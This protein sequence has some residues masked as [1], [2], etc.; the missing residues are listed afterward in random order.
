MS[1]HRNYAAGTALY[2]QSAEHSVSVAFE[3]GFVQID[4]AEMYRNEAS[5]GSAIGKL[6]SGPNAPPRQSIFVT[7]KL[8]TIPDGKTVKDSI[9]ESL[10]K[11]QINYIDL[12]L[13][14]TPVPHE[15]RIKEVWE[16]MEEVYKE[17]LA[18][19]IGVS[20]FRPKDF[21]EFIDTA[22]VIPAVNQIEFNPYLLNAVEPFL[23]L[24][25]KYNILTVSY[26][27]LRLGKEAGKEVTNGQVLL[28]WLDAYGALPITTSSKKDRLINLLETPKLPDL[29]ADELYVWPGA[30]N[31]PS[32]DSQCLIAILYLQLSFPGRFTIVEC[33]NPDISPLGQLPFLVHGNHSVSTVSAIVAYLEGLEESTSPRPI[34]GLDHEY[35]VT[36]ALDHDLSPAEVAKTVAWTSYIDS[37]LGDLVLQ[38]FYALAPNFRKLTLPTLASFLPIPQKYYIPSRLRDMYKPRLEAAGLWELADDDAADEHGAAA[39]KATKWMRNPLDKA[40]EGTVGEEPPEQV[41]KAFA[42]EK[43]IERAKST[44]QL[45]ADL[46]PEGSFAFGERPTPLD[47]HLTAHVLLI[48]HAPLPNPLLRTLVLESFPTLVDHALLV[49]TFAFPSQPFPITHN[50]IPSQVSGKAQQHARQLPTSSPPLPYPPIQ[51]LQHL[52][53]GESFKLVWDGVLRTARS[54]RIGIPGSS[55]SVS[56]VDLNLDDA[57]PLERAEA[58]AEKDLKKW[59]W[60]FYTAAG[61][62]LVTYGI[63]SGILP[64][65]VGLATGMVRVEVHDGEEEEDG[66]HGSEEDDE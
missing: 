32:I 27:G 51:S 61:V 30:W 28:K 43:V 7:T 31:L 37:N 58:E 22:E 38:S 20:N 45:L 12:Y 56:P 13:I 16:Q 6:L 46:I 9:K 64:L 11:L 48:L 24:H 33:A 52:S 66:Q 10:R 17:G 40:K 42:R 19:N 44:F 60:A 5:V 3:A 39:Q 62:G 47:I 25:K 49:R 18:K 50:G 55:P 21:A 23:A 59:R 14:H 2:G 54:I 36:P 35:P 34:E 26:G 15:G 53:P 65:L 63:G 29:T 4:C 57:T 41:K 8:N 1:S